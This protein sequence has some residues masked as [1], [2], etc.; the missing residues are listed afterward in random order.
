M[1]EKLFGTLHTPLKP[2]NY[3]GK[4]TDTIQV[5]VDSTNRIISANL[6]PSVRDNMK[7][8][9]AS[10]REKLDTLDETINGRLDDIDIQISADLA[11]IDL[12]VTNNLTDISNTKQE[13]IDKVNAELA[14]LAAQ[15]LEIT[16]DFAKKFEQF[17]ANTLASIGSKLAEAEDT[18]KVAREDLTKQVAD[19]E[20]ALSDQISAAKTDLAKDITA[21]NE[22]LTSQIETEVANLSGRLEDI[23]TKAAEDVIEDIEAQLITSGTIKTKADKNEVTIKDKVL[24]IELATQEFE[25]DK[26]YTKEDIDEMLG[27]SSSIEQAIES[28]LGGIKF[29]KADI[30]MLLPEENIEDNV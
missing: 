29:I 13:L 23:A 9:L 4:E 6:N 20:A 2:I 27:D 15:V 22:E 3:E 8:L 10:L 16:S 7:D 14:R 21:S 19:A 17:E 24:T 11:R 1:A 18:I 26:Y 28:Y 12:A 5:V 25:S 30:S